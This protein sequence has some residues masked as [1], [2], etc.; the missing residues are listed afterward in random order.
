MAAAISA[1]AGIVSIHAQT[2]RDAKGHLT[3]L[4]LLVDPTP[5][6]E[7]VIVWVVE[8]G[9]PSDEAKNNVVAPAVSATNPPTG[10]NLVSLEPI[11]FTILNPPKRVPIAIVEYDIRITQ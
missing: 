6:I 2:M 5:T 8:T 9:I 4:N 7:P 1:D 3:A 10:F 11:V